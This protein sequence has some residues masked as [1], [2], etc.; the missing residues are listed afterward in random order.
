MSG[1][2][3][4]VHEAADAVFGEVDGVSVPRH[5]GDPAAEYT[6]ALEA[7]AVIDRSHRTRL[8]ISGKAPAQMLKGLLSGRIPDAPSSE[9]QVEHTR[10]E[11][12]LVLTP[13]G[14]I[15]SD[16]R[17]TRLAGEDEVFVFD[18]PVVGAAPLAE[19]LK[20]SL[21]PRLAT[22]EDISSGTGMLTV[23]GP[24]AA[25]LLSRDVLGLRVQEA[26][27]DALGDGDGVRLADGDGVG[28]SVVRTAEVATVAFDVISDRETLAAVWKRLME[29][30][31]S[32]VGRGVFETLR[33]EAGR[34]ALGAD[35]GERTIPFEAGIVERAIDHSKGCYTGQEVIVR[36]RD[37]GH[38][39]RRLCGLLLG[40]GPTPPPGTEIFGP[41]GD[42]PVGTLTS[43]A[44]SPRAD[45]VIALG[46]V[47][48]GVDA[49]G[50][51]RVGSV[52]GPEAELRELGEG[53]A[54]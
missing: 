22:A 20:R 11:Y 7:V 40:D 41:E 45:G 4:K 29:G 25:G 44:H 36:I 53:W 17:V 12:S 1:V 27:L 47:R 34:P 43:L 39:N 10:W 52:E 51:V 2:L 15:L 19:H 33:V 32:A 24:L 30:G 5:Y 48:R 3:A 9:G 16:L 38:V 37:R 23:M 42:K 21:P 31:A 8:R 14:R 54:F 6:G 50:V 18:V 49:P 46:Y 35:L 26:E 13:K 28:I